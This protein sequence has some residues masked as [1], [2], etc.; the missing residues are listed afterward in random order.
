MLQQC[1]LKSVLLRHLQSE[2]RSGW[3]GDPLDPTFWKP[4]V[5]GLVNSSIHMI[6]KPL[7]KDQLFTHVESRVSGI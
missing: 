1:M 3:V 6:V 5:N 7:I 2:D 4:Q